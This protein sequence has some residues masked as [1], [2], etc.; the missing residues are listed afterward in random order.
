MIVSLEVH[1]SLEQ[2]AVMVEIMREVWQGVLLDEP[3]CS[4]SERQPSPDELRR[5]ILVKVKAASKA[6]ARTTND[7]AGAERSY[8]PDDTSSSSSSSSDGGVARP[9]SKKSKMLEALSALGVYTQAYHFSS[10]DQPGMYMGALARIVDLL[11]PDTPLPLQRRPYPHTS[12]RCRRGLLWTCGRRTR[13]NYFRTIG[14]D[15]LM[16]PCRHGGFGRLTVR[17]SVS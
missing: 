2:Q 10:F 17:P 14:F 7:A 9:K 12:F 15:P 11:R 3:T 1:A 4:E 6:P 5:K 13:R 16:R 8:D